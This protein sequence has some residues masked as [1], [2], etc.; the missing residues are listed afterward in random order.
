MADGS[1]ENNHRIVELPVH[2]FTYLHIQNNILWCA[3]RAEYEIR[4]VRDEYSL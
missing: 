2:R 4:A 1:K 3:T